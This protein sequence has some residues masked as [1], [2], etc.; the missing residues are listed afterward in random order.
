MTARVVNHVVE[1][2]LRIRCGAG[3]LPIENLGPKDCIAA[4]TIDRLVAPGIDQPGSR[5][6]RH[7]ARRP[8][9]QRGG[10][11][12]LPRLFGQIEIAEQADQC[13]E[14]TTRLSAKDC[15]DC[16]IGSVCGHTRRM[17]A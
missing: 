16:L 9:L 1:N 13:C 12:F 15:F 3:D 10:E 5:I 2:A 14:N 17:R 7:A 4:D 8:L 11:C 6:L